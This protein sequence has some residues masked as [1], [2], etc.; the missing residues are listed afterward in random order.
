MSNPSLLRGP[1]AKS[2]RRRLPYD[3]EKEGESHAHLNHDEGVS[4]LAPSRDILMRWVFEH[5]TAV[6][7][8]A[9][10]RRRV[11]AEGD[12]KASHYRKS[13]R[14]YNKSR[15]SIQAQHSAAQRSPSNRIRAKAM[16]QNQNNLQIHW[17]CS[18]PLHLRG[19]PC[20]TWSPPM[21][22]DR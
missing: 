19:D 13:F 15:V 4:V 20:Q 1:R 3:A 5:A 11:R 10:C 21:W 8:D 17:H 6:V 16:P 18:Q 9:C 7:S 12:T 14:T 22:C 2:E